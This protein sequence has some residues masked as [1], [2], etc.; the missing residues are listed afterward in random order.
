MAQM[1]TAERQLP[2]AAAAGVN[3]AARVS[4]GFLFLSRSLESPACL[5][6]LRSVSKSLPRACAVSTVRSRSLSFFSRRF[7]RFFPLPRAETSSYGACHA[8]FGA[9][10]TP[11]RRFLD[12]SAVRRTPHES[13]ASRQL[14]RRA[15]SA[16]ALKRRLSDVLK[17]LVLPKIKGLQSY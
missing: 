3:A 1:R 2:P 7:S 13:K 14:R 12:A 15:F 8:R 6:S 5:L 10:W 11:K 17:T 16:L 4:C 9:I